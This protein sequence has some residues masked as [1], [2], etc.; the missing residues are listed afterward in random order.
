MIIMDGIEA[1]KKISAYLNYNDASSYIQR[2]S[3]SE[4]KDT[5]NEKIPKIFAVTGDAYSNKSLVEEC[6]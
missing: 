2:F 4:S 6:K 3:Q 1:C 5:Q